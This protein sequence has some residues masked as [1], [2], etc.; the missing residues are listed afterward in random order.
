MPVVAALDGV[1][2][3][4]VTRQRS[5][6]VLWLT[7]FV[8]QLGFGIVVPFLPLYADKLGASGFEVGLALAVYS[9]AQML[10][11]QR[12]GRFSD[13]I[14]R[15]P[16][17]VAGAIGTCAGFVVLATA[18]SL[19]M[20]F[21]GRAILG[22]FGI[23][24]QT[25]QAW[26]ADTTPPEDR[27]RALALL[28]AAA[29]LGFVLGPAIGALGILAGG[30]RLPFFLAGG[31]AAINAVLTRTVLP[32]S[33]PIAPIGRATKAEGWRAIAPCL[34]V[35]FVLTY[36]FS[37]VEAT[38]ALFTK[39]ALGFAP[40]DNG[41]LF[42]ALGLIA[43]A[44]QVFAMRW[45]SAHVREAAR[46][47]LGLVILGAGV[48]AMPSATSLATLLPP[49]ALLAIGYAIVSPSLAAWVS[50]RAPAD[51]QGELLGLTQ[52][53]S[54]LARVAGP[55]IGGWLFDHVGRG[56]PFHVAAIVIGGSAV[57]AI[58]ARRT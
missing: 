31:F 4:A 34:V 54:A 27:G 12:W 40:Q 56:V 37:G 44:T 41:W 33:T 46:V 6:A 29:G 11:S 57:V 25:A 52:S 58:A 39:D 50:R 20:L 49:L 21:V 18:T 28:G 30:M 3:A 2:F 53:T 14:G 55:G 23:G 32:R 9:L 22:S 26:V 10:V 42:G 24:M 13:R 17:I 5:L 15:R 48:G 51:R 43:V 35:A 19:P 1:T 45:L 8:D 38:F 16:V 47:A 7:V 36:A